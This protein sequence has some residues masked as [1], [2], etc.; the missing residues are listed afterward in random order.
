[1]IQKNFEI[2]CKVDSK[3]RVSIPSWMRR[4]IGI[5]NTVVSILFDMESNFVILEFQPPTEPLKARNTKINY[6]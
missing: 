1:M 5:E 3:G 6:D 2:K 4:Y